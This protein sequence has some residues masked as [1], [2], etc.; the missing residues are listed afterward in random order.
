MDMMRPVLLALPPLAPG[1]LAFDTTTSTLTFND[2]S[3]TETSFLVQKSLDGVTWADVGTLDSPLDQPNVHGPRS[4]ADPTFDPL[5]TTSYRV[6]ARNTVGATGAILAGGYSG[7]TV[8]SMSP[9]LLVGVLTPTTT[10]LTS[11]INPSTFGQNVTFTATVSAATGTPTGT[12]Q[13][14]VDGTNV[15]APVVLN[16]S[17]VATFATSTLSIASHTV[18]ALYGGSTF[19]DTSVGTLTQVVGKAPSTTA[20][21]SSL[22]PSF[23]GQS[24]TLTATVSPAAATGQVVFNIDTIDVATVPLVAGKASYTTT[25]L[26]AGTHPVMATYG[27]D[28]TYTTSNATLTQSVSP[29][30]AT[31]TSLTTAP[32]PSVYGQN[33]TFTA[34]VSPTAAT[35]TVVF[36]ID[37][38]AGAPIALNASGVASFATAALTAGSH[39]VVAT[40]GGNATYATS[41]STTLT[42]VV[43]KALTTTTVRSS[44]TNGRVTDRITL[45]ATTNVV[46]PG[47]GTRTGTV[48]FKLTNATA[49][50]V[51]AAAVPIGANG[52]TTFQWTLL[53]P[54]V[55]TWTLTATYSGD[56]NFAGSLG[57]LANQRVR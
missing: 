46:A 56:A 48:Q 47:A 51:L 50:L 16:A 5:L 32:N 57:T 42:Q 37:N 35:G 41:A 7:T 34:T 26:L 49:T 39:S 45:T 54:Q 12:V 18:E 1:S 28:A 27:G 24:V 30:I 20:L 43:N 14:S 11:D 17:G 33:V 55:G 4:L 23:L 22:N 44:D 40:Y 2:N 36:T 25:S 10:V 13:F 15:G 19:H 6:V 38:V 21:T 3:I 53:A 52:V 9:A 29:L 8:Q 31:T